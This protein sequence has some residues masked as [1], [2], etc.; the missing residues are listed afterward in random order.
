MVHRR[1]LIFI[2]PISGTRDKARL[3]SLILSA[4]ERLGHSCEV[5]P[6]SKDGNYPGLAEELRQRGITDVVICGGD[7]TINQVGAALRGY[8]GRVGVMPA[9]SGNGLALGAGISPDYHKALQVILAGKA[10]YIDGFEVNGRFGCMLTGLGFDAEVAADFSRQKTRG[11]FP[12]VKL[13]F[14]R[15]F[16]ARAKPFVLHWNGQS[17]STEALFV[18]VAN[19][20]QFGSRIRIAPRASLSDGW[21]DVVVVHRGNKAF[22]VW[23]LLRQISLGRIRSDEQVMRRAS[24]VSYFHTR[25]IRIENPSSAP[26]HID[27]EPVATAPALDI[28]VIPRVFR[29]MVP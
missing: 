24:G 8:E 12:Y 23:S 15:F 7:G 26:L 21:L 20:N 19:S 5:R 17:M 22:T 14:L 2:N 16:R 4:C 25:T 9:G 1:F 28:C 13:S 29:L 18:S 3:S 6:T 27:G 11:L 10:E